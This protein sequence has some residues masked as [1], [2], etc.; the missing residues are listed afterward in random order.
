VNR[1]QIYLTDYE[2]SGIKSYAQDLGISMSEYIRRI[3][4]EHLEKRQSGD[5]SVYFKNK[6]IKVN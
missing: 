3:I 4:D 2:E 1:R 5:A 6:E